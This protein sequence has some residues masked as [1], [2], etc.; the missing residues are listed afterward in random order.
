M[1]NGSTN[2]EHLAAIVFD[3][4]AEKGVDAVSFRTVASA[5]EV[6]IGAVQHHFSSKADLQIFVF[7]WLVHRVE[8]RIGRC[9]PDSPIAEKLSVLLREL[10][11]LDEERKREGLVML[12]FASLA[13]RNP[14]LAQIQARTLS[15]IRRDLA[16]Q[17]EN[18]GHQNCEVKA[19][20]LLA[21]ADGLT[22]D[23]LSTGSAW[24][25]EHVQAS[26]DA[27]IQAI[28]SS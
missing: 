25:P 8:S 21:A 15:G 9:S 12:D 11:P 17:L 1:A 23:Y 5:A 2:K 19:T 4:A 26:L 13:A 7:E 3:I 18:T 20:L 6:S 28:L 22:L 27:Q 10:L 16:T 24:G 14:A